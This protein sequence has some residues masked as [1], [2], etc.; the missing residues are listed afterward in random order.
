MDYERRSIKVGAQVDAICSLMLCFGFKKSKHTDEEIIFSCVQ[1]RPRS[2]VCVPDEQ[3]D[4][5]V[6]VRRRPDEGMSDKYI[7]SLQRRYILRVLEAARVG[8]DLVQ[9]EET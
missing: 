7:M 8:F 4:L 6:T 3:G 5:S 1:G 2:F 9:G